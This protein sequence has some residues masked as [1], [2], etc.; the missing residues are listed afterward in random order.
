LDMPLT[1]SHTRRSGRAGRLEKIEEGGT[2]PRWGVDPK[3]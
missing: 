1:K 3:W 2:T